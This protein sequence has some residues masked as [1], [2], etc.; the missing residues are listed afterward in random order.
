MTRGTPV[1]ALLQVGE[2]VTRYLRAGQGSPVILV[3][4]GDDVASMGRT[5]FDALSRGWKVVWPTAPHGAPSR[6]WLED[7]AQGLGLDVPAIV[8]VCGTEGPEASWT[9]ALTREGD[10]V[11]GPVIRVRG[12]DVDAAREGSRLRATCLSTVSHGPGD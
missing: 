5:L 11:L 3:T 7:V 12:A 6:S 1:D 2:V 8:A 10:A 4:E 9:E